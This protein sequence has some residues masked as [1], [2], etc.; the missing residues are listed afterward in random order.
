MTNELK[1]TETNDLVGN[2]DPIS[3]EGDVHGFSFTTEN[4]IPPVQQDNKD[5]VKLDSIM[6]EITVFLEKLQANPDKAI[7]RWP[8]RAKEAKSFLDKLE[9]IYK[10]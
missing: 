9:N 1:V 8:D 6:T 3:T 5:K 4:D 2:S 7:L 10:G